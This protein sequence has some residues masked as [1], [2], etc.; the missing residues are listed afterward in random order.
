M[1]KKILPFRQSLRTPKPNRWFIGDMWRASVASLEPNSYTQAMNSANSDLWLAAMNE[2]IDSL[3]LMDTWNYVDR[4][5]DKSII[6]CRWVFK[7]KP[8]T[9]VEPERYKARLVAKGYSQVPGLDFKDTFSPVIRFDT[10]RVMIAFG[11]HH[12]M[13]MHQMDVKT[14]FL[15]GKL[16]ENIFMQQPPGFEVHPD[17]VCK[18]NRSLYGLKQSPRMWNIELSKFLLDMKFT[19]SSYDSC[20][21]IKI[22]VSGMTFIL[23]YVDDLIVMSSCEKLLVSTKKSLCRRFSMKDLGILAHFLGVRIRFSFIDGSRSVLMDQNSH[24]QKVLSQFRMHQ[25]NPAKT[26]LDVATKLSADDCPATEDLKKIMD[27][28][29]YR[30]AVGSLVYLATCTRP[31]IATAVSKVSQFMHNPGKNHWTAVKRIFRY[32]KG[33]PDYS[34]QFSNQPPFELIGYSD[35]DWAGDIDNRRSTSGSL[36]MLAGGPIIWKSVKQRTVALSTMEAEYIALSAVIQDVMWSRNLLT[37][38]GFD[39]PGP[40]TVY[41]DNQSCIAYAK[42]SRFHNRAKHIDIRYHFVREAV[43]SNVV[44]LSYLSTDKMVADILTKALSFPVFSR[45]TDTLMTQS[46]SFT[47]EEEYQNTYEY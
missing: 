15:N 23:V 4:P 7:I 14:A 43:A 13:L 19:R 41:E 3:T 20:L 45:F 6:S 42:D 26:P 29:P 18:L 34:I 10:I 46:T 36:L 2:E 31:D 38:I 25:C 39:A 17:L 9:D 44:S 21:F 16:E 8:A 27:Q 37:E 28:I 1:K 11:I 32:L 5:P 33:T 24:V 40:T 30:A 12:N 22:T 47:S 35:S